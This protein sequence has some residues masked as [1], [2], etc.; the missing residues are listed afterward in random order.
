M[1]RGSSEGSSKGKTDY[2]SASIYRSGR[3]VAPSDLSNTTANTSILG[4]EVSGMS[5]ALQ[6][7][8]AKVDNRQTPDD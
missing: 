6:R 5:A 7:R 8:H 2:S 3:D 1:T 4:R